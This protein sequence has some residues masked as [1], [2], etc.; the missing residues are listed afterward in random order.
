MTAHGSNKAAATSR[1][2]VIARWEATASA[3]FWVPLSSPVQLPFL[4][5]FWTKLSK[6]GQVA[7]RFKWTGK[8]IKSM[9]DGINNLKEREWIKDQAHKTPDS[10]TASIL[11]TKVD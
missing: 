10:V 7:V 1:L 11:S 3:D 4:A 8:N 6:D 2:R 9:H 5:L